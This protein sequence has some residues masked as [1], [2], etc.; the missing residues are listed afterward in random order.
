MND[1]RDKFPIGMRVLAIDDDRTCLKILEKLLL[2]CQYHGMCMLF[3]FQ[4]FF[5]F[6]VINLNHRGIL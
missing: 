4:W 3:I 6:D 2:K 5:I 1:L